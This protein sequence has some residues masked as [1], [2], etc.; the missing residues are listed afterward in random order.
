M[1]YCGAILTVY[2]R[3][4]ILDANYSLK[5]DGTVRV[6]NHAEK[7][8]G[9]AK[10]VIGDAIQEQPNTGKFGVR[11]YSSAPY[12]PYWVINMINDSNGKYSIA[13]VWSCEQH[14]GLTTV[15]DLWILS[16]S[17]TI[18]DAQ[19]NEML[20]YANSTGIP[21]DALDMQRT[22]QTGCKAYNY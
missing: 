18:T 2:I 1:Y 14:G 5:T 15:D 7:E 22:N 16:R 17:L 6:D 21:V 13:L 12:S 20:S 3:V 19:Y 8:D 9:S 10:D 4:Y 11:F